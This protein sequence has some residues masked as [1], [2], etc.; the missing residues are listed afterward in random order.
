MDQTA[1]KRSQTVGELIVSLETLGELIDLDTGLVASRSPTRL[2][3]PQVENTLKH[4]LKVGQNAQNWASNIDE[5]LLSGLDDPQKPLGRPGGNHPVATSTSSSGAV[6]DM[7]KLKQRAE[8]SLALLVA[9]QSPEERTNAV[10]AID[11]LIGILHKQIELAEIRHDHAKSAEMRSLKDFV[12]QGKANQLQDAANL[13][14][15]SD[16]TSYEE[17]LFSFL[18]VLSKLESMPKIVQFFDPATGQV[19]VSLSALTIPAHNGSASA[20]IQ[21]VQQDP[22]LANSPYPGKTQLDVASSLFSSTEELRTQLAKARISLEQHRKRHPEDLS[23]QN[24]IDRITDIQEHLVEVQYQVKTKYM[25]VAA[26]PVMQAP[27]MS[28]NILPA[29]EYVQPSY[30]HNAVHVGQPN[31]SMQPQMQPSYHAQPV[32]YQ[33]QQP[34]QQYHPPNTGHPVYRRPLDDEFEL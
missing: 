24:L 14:S 4:I 20:A 6:G 7:E 31:L 12:L 34:V 27:H 3:T 15:Q 33:P 30:H 18:D 23:V 29:Q 25:P 1:D 16:V 32:N 21:Q 2:F 9:S 10:A 28:A 17:Q 22:Q 11:E 8:V 5:Q 19:Q 26:Q 13:V